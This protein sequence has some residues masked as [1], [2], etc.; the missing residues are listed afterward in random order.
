MTRFVVHGAQL[1]GACPEIC[2]EPS[3]VSAA[4]RMRTN[5]RRVTDG[6][7]VRQCVTEAPLRR[8]L[9]TLCA[10]NSGYAGNADLKTEFRHRGGLG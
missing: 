3:G 10:E 9:E 8:R 4:G 2:P 7:L 6:I 5:T 1:I